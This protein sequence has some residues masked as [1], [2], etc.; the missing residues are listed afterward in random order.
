[1]SKTNGIKINDTLIKRI[2]GPVNFCLLSP[3]KNK[4]LEELKKSNI[5]PPLVMLFGDSHFSSENTCEKCNNE[6]NCFSIKENSFLQLIDNL[7]DVKKL[8]IDF[9]IEHPFILS[10]VN[11]AEVRPGVLSELK[12][13]I[14]PCLRKEKTCITK[15][16]KWTYVDTRNT[17]AN[18]KYYYE[19][20]FSK[21]YDI[22]VFLNQTIKTKK[23]KEDAIYDI[24]DF[25]TGICIKNKSYILKHKYFKNIINIIKTLKNKNLDTLFDKNNILNSLICKQIKKLNKPL[26]DID[27]WKDKCSQY[28]KYKLRN[29]PDEAI[30]DLQNFFI[31]MLDISDIF[32]K[33]YTKYSRED[34]IDSIYDAYY[35]KLTDI[36]LLLLDNINI[37][38]MLT[39]ISIFLDLYY[40]TRMLKVPYKS[41]NTEL[42]IGYMGFNHVENITYFLT[43]ILKFYEIN[44]KIDTTYIKKEPKRCLVFEKYIDLDNI[45]FN[46]KF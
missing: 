25:I 33:N 44:S 46:S 39:I 24:I 7:S 23:H 42:S 14:L 43:N 30:D 37:D 41:K 18:F 40:I 38:I 11:F 10:D 15:N 4:N 29:I 5:H 2:S 13:K 32:L 1:M 21:Y 26:N 9:N 35:E 3:I 22:L 34:L 45:I 12:Y 17:P 6:D 28:V 8:S 16:I 19:N 36:S 27:F 20:D 31:I